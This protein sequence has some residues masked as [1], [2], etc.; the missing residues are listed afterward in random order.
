MDL[1]KTASFYFSC[2]YNQ[3][4]IKFDQIELATYTWN[5]ARFELI[6]D[7]HLIGVDD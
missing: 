1:L 4:Y 2:E 7:S 3:S 6:V 5:L